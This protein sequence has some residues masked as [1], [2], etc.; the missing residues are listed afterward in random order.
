LTVAEALTAY[1][2]R[3][4]IV[5]WLVPPS[6]GLGRFPFGDCCTSQS[7]GSHRGRGKGFYGDSTRPLSFLAGGEPNTMTP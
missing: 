5:G 6:T 3:R 2:P 7:R 1:E 4:L